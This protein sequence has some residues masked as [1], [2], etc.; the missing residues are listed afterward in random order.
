VIENSLWRAAK[1]SDVNRLQQKVILAFK[2]T[3]MK[4]IIS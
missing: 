3:S 2:K 1:I 4:K